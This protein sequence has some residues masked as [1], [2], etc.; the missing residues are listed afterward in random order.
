M[1]VGSIVKT[2][3]NLKGVCFS[4]DNC[5]R[6]GILFQDGS[7]RFYTKA[8]RLHILT[9]INVDVSLANYKYNNV[10]EMR[11]DFEVGIFDEALGIVK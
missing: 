10:K 1:I 7:H 9:P 5:M 8:E 3:Q 11:V 6:A 4:K 2:K